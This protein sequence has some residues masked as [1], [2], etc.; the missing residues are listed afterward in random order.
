M[1][2]VDSVSPPFQ[3]D[4]SHVAPPK[5]PQCVKKEEVFLVHSTQLAVQYIY[6]S[7]PEGLILSQTSA[8]FDRCLHS[9]IMDLYMPVYRSSPC[10]KWCPIAG[11]PEIVYYSCA[12]LREK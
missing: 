6:R 2:A 11:V 3:T 4:T 12:V 8:Y 1:L 5:R 10:L 7:M 9:K